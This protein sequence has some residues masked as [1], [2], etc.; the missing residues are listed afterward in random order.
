MTYDLLDLTKEIKK[1]IKFKTAHR[2]TLILV[3]NCLWTLQEIKE[4]YG[5]W[6]KK[7][8]RVCKKYN[9]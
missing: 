8:V 5:A 6:R 4:R 7:Y 2:E 9:L 1:E 3:F